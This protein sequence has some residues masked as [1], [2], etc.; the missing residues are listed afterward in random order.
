MLPMWSVFERLTS[1]ILKKHTEFT[2]PRDLTSGYSSLICRLE[3]WF[4]MLSNNTNVRRNP[5]LPHQSTSRISLILHEELLFDFHHTL[6]IVS[7]L[8]RILFIIILLPVL[9]HLIDLSVPII[10]INIC[11]PR[12][13]SNLCYDTI[14][15]CV[16]LAASSP[17]KVYRK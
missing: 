13:T 16:I 17:N 9:H 8:D 15:L 6:D 5:L 12:I 14:S 11:P 10:L 1:R 7:A 2:Y 3:E 4:E